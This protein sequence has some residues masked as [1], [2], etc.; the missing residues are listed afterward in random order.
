LNLLAWDTF[1]IDL[2]AQVIYG[3]LKSEVTKLIESREKD[4]KQPWSL[5]QGEAS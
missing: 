1:D 4:T 2:E 3:D 5:W